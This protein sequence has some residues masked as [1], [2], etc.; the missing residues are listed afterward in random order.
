MLGKQTSGLY[1]QV[2]PN[3]MCRWHLT[4]Y[5]RVNRQ[6][7]NTRR[8]V[9]SFEGSIAGT[10][11]ALLTTN[12]LGQPACVQ[13]CLLKQLKV[14]FYHTCPSYPLSVHTVDA[15]TSPHRKPGLKQTNYI[16]LKDNSL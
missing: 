10:R 11:I 3:L 8:Y 14:T 4:A 15:N 9:V 6:F 1:Q 7:V 16:H 5:Y 12:V 13:R 2:T